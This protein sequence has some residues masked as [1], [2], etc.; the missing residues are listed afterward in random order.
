MLPLKHSYKK[1]IL[2]STPYVA[3]MKPRLLFCR[4]IPSQACNITSAIFTVWKVSKSI[5]AK[6][7]VTSGRPPGNPSSPPQDNSKPLGSDTVSREEPDSQFSVGGTAVISHVQSAE[8]PSFCTEGENILIKYGWRW[9]RSAEVKSCPSLNARWVFKFNLGYSGVKTR[10]C[11]QLPTAKQ[12]RCSGLKEEPWNPVKSWDQ[13]GAK[14]KG[15][16]HVNT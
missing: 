6:T 5:R 15:N 3:E 2:K 9:L 14:G 11:L 8:S 4:G 13:N 16:T 7:S 1:I 12:S 10:N